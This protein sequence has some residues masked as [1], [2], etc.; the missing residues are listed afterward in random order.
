MG[1]ALISRRGRTA[2]IRPKATA[3]EAS[4]AARELGLRRMRLAGRDGMSK[5]GTLGANAFWARLTPEERRL[6]GRRRAATRRKNRA[7]YLEKLLAKR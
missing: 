6:E 4:A 2:G 7:A 1:A 3:E 5:L